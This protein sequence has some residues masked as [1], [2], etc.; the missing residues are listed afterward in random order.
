MTAA[1]N[2]YNSVKDI[3][4]NEKFGFED[5][6]CEFSTPLDAKLILTITQIKVS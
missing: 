6:K 4:E 3:F 1:R 2:G 5:I